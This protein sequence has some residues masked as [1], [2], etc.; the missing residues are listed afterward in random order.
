MPHFNGCNDSSWIDLSLLS[1][2]FTRYSN[3]IIWISFKRLKWLLYGC[4]FIN[5]YITYYIANSWSLTQSYYVLLRIFWIIWRVYLWW[6]IYMWHR[7]QCYRQQSM[8][9]YGE[10]RFTTPNP[11]NEWNTSGMSICIKMNPTI[12]RATYISIQYPTRWSSQ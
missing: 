4:V 11:H 2:Q 1:F 9:I 5:N 10:L 8:D 6:S 7:P 3:K 12:P